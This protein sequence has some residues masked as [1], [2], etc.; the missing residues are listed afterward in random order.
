[1]WEDIIKYSAIPRG[2][3]AG[4]ACGIPD[5]KTYLANPRHRESV[6]ERTSVK[7]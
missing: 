7:F 6:L 3:T 1:M 4:K 2:K 5:V